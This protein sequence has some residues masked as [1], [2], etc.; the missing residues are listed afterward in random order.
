LVDQKFAFPLPKGFPDQHAAPL[1][2]AGVIGYRALRLSGARKGSLLGLFGFGASAHL[3]LQMARHRGCR[4]FVFTRAA[5]H[6]E[7]ARK[8]GAEWAGAAEDFAPEPMDQAIIFA[9]AGELVPLA[10]R[11]VRKGGT[12][13]L[14]GIVMS[15]IPQM[16]Y[17]L[18]YFERVLR[19]VAN[20][21]RDDVRECLQL[22][23]EIPLR[24]E[25][26]VFPLEQANE[27]LLALK[28]SKIRAAGVLKIS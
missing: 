2:C 27:A 15:P 1:L 7:L 21:T 9:P 8:M 23:G 4:V 10:L 16:D 3:V 5:S 25:I 11:H 18:L 14:A 24:T 26:E 28:Q 17:S 20:S 22:A 6:Q 19:S 12:V 13:A